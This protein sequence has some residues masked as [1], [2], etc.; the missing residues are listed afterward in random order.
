MW[1]FSNIKIVTSD[2]FKPCNR[3]MLV[4]ASRHAKLFPAILPLIFIRTT[5]KITNI[6]AGY[7][8]LIRRLENYFVLSV[9]IWMMILDTGCSMR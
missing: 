3:S 7:L 4:Y 1:L 6:Q 5:P 8:K 2:F 9:T